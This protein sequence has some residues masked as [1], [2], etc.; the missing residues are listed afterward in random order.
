MNN[1]FCTKNII[2]GILIVLLIILI[3]NM[4]CRDY[5]SNNNFKSSNE[6]NNINK[7]TETAEKIF[8]YSKSLEEHC[9]N[10]KGFDFCTN[11]LKNYFNTE[12]N[13]ILK[14]NDNTLFNNFYKTYKKDHCNYSD[15]NRQ[16]SC[17][18]ASFIAQYKEY[19]VKS[20]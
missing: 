2:T 17:E 1:L 5:F 8:N 12:T 18:E 6:E 16:N 4:F 19:V 13:N 14:S 10:T 15:K 7:I 20:Y 11:K 3:I 9:I